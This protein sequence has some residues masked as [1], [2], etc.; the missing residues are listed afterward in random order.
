MFIQSKRLRMAAVVAGSVLAGG[1]MGGTAVAFQSHMFNALH[2]LQVARNQL[3]MAL[4]DKGG[5]RLQAMSLVDQ[6]I[7]A[8]NAGISAGAQ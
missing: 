7:S 2:A 4:P 6:A 1:V 5:Y 8:T 3:N